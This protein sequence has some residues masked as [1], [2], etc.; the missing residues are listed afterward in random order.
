MDQF[1][2]I[3]PKFREV[4][5]QPDED[6]I[7]F[8][9]TKRWINYPVADQVI[10]HLHDLLQHPKQARMPSVLFVGDSNNGKTSLIE[11]F[12]SLYGESYTCEDTELLI[13][14]IVMTEISAPNVKDLYLSILEQFWAPH[15]P[16][17]TVAQLRHVALHHLMQSKTKMLILDEFHTLNNGSAIKRNE[18]LAELK[19]ISNKLRI[20][21]VACGIP[22]AAT[23]I[24]QDAQIQSRFSVLRLP[25]WEKNRDFVALLK[26]FE[27]MLPLKQPSQL[28]SKELGSKIFNIS[29]GNLGNIHGLLQKCAIKA[30]TSGVEQIDMEIVESFSWYTPTEGP[31]EIEL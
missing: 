29:K 30:I 28:A 14:P 8:I 22:K 20:P 25:T 23:I 1:Q 19:M 16:T 21:I 4:A 11:R 18:A 5:A 26:A 27:K 15:K 31:R 2:H 10:A 17:Y 7:Q 3:I 12:C 13:K 6:R 9:K 24:S